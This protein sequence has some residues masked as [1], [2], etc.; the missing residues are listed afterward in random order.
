MDEEA[1][2]AVRAHAVA[3]RRHQ[4]ASRFLPE[5]GPKLFSEQWRHAVRPESE[6]RRQELF[7]DVEGLAKFNLQIAWCPY[8]MDVQA[9]AVRDAIWQVKQR[10]MEGQALAS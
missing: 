5:R 3:R 2:R 4:K 9:K 8:G 1:W 7:W 6:Q 10:W